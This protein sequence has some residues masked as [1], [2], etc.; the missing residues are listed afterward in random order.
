MGYRPDSA[1]DWSGGALIRGGCWRS[2]D[3]AGAFSLN[4]DWP[5]IDYDRVGF[6]CTK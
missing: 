2:D 5:D 1:R 6:R 4:H 3:C